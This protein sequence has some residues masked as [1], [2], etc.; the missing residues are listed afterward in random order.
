MQ[1]EV[2]AAVDADRLDALGK[3]KCGVLT[4]VLDTGVDRAH[5]ELAG[6]LRQGFDFCARLEGSTCRGSDNVP[7]EVTAGDVGHGTSSAGLIAANTNNGQGIAGLTW[8]GTI[9]PV[10]V[11]GTDGTTTGATSASSTTS[12]VPRV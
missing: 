12:I 8:G 11:F 2:W 3:T 5:P 1:D 4:A 7:D 10:K 6:R 9:L